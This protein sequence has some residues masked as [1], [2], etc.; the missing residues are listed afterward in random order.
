MRKGSSEASAA[1]RARWLADVAA[2]LSEAQAL[3]WRLGTSGKRPEA[4]ELYSQIELAM[5]EVRALR[6]GRSASRLEE[7]DPNWSKDLP[8]QS[9]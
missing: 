7:H 4:M 9:R 6:L 2:T 8:W 3:T 5:A 1:D